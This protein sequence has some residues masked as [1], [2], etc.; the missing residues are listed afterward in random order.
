MKS[1]FTSIPKV[2]YASFSS[3]RSQV[4]LEQLK[5]IIHIDK[6]YNIIESLF[7]LCT[8][9]ELLY[10]AST[11]LNISLQVHQGSFLSPGTLKKLADTD[12]KRSCLAIL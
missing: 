6:L 8:V 2:Y 12:E 5:T 10:K 7:T 3:Q 1:S 4:Q 9:H 11:C